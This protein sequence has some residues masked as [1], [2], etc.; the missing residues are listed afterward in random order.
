MN[1][2]YTLGLTAVAVTV[3]AATAQQQVIQFQRVQ[4]R[5]TTAPASSNSPA[6]NEFKPDENTSPDPKTLEVPAEVQKQALELVGQ[7]GNPAYRDRELA[8]RELGKLGRLALPALRQASRSDIPEVVERAEALLPRALALDM[9]ARVACF[10]ADTEGKYEH[11]MPGWG[12]FQA[13]AGNSKASRELFAEA[14]KNKQTH[15]MLMAAEGTPEDASTVLSDFVSRLQGYNRFGGNYEQ[16]ATPKTAELLVALFLEAQY[17]DKQVVITMPWMWGGGWFSVA[18]HVFNSGDFQN[19]LRQSPSGKYSE[20]IRKVVQKWMDSRETT[21]GCNQAWNFAQQMFGSKNALKYAAKVLAADSS[22]NTQYVKQSVLTQMGQNNAKEFVPEI[23]KCFDDATVLWH[24]QNGT[25]NE[26]IQLRDFA[27]AV[28]VQLTD[29]DPKEYAFDRTGGGKG[30]NYN[31]NTFY[32]KDDR[33]EKDREANPNVRIGRAGGGRLVEPPAEKPKPAEKPVVPEKS[34]DPG[35]KLSADDKRK[36]AFK[37][38][39]DWQATQANK[40]PKSGG[41]DKEMSKNE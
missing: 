29:Q 19:A 35:K 16:P 41:A 18:S 40:E 37:K 20:P 38:W 34:G 12:K 27:L 2:R 3:G 32:F 13:A 6:D 4:L 5:P 24:A 25:P 14:L 33:D 36:A 9:K 30:K 26:E 39:A 31:L 11:T 28:C 17:S 8:S 23:T 10:L 15:Q 7:L 22:P 1:V 21:N